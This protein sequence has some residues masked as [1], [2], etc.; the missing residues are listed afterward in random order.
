MVS[1]SLHGEDPEYLEELSMEVEE[2]MRGLDHL[3]EVWGPTMRGTKE[4]RLLVD[5]RPPTA[6]EVSPRGIADAVGFA[7]RGRRLRRFQGPD[8][9]VEMV[10]G[11]PEEAQPGIDALADLPVPTRSGGYVPLSSVAEVTI[12]RTPERIHRENR[13]T[14]QR[15]TGPVRQ[16][17]RDD[18]RS[19]EAGRGTHGRVHRSRRL[20]VGFRAVGTR[21]RRGPGNHVPRGVCCR[22]WR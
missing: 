15:V 9:E 8:G 13:Q 22:W 17:R 21:P 10:L 14:T 1:V 6:L 5:A 12:A 16:G 11:L 2:R 7:F 4:L 3:E 19:E 20:L 18:G